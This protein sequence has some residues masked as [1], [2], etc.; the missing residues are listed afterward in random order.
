MINK[1]AKKVSITIEF[2]EDDF[3]VLEGQ[4]LLK[5]L[6]TV[7]FIRHAAFEEALCSVIRISPEDQDAFFDVP[8]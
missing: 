2:D 4:A 3:L 5:G 7:E 1:P 6:S 8:R